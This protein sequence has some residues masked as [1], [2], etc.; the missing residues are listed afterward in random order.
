MDK[1]VDSLT[2]YYKIKG[3]VPLD[4]VE[5][6]RYGFKLI[7]SDIFNFFL[8]ISIGFILGETLSGIVFLITLCSI[9]QYSGGFHAKTFWLCRVSLLITFLCVIYITH[10]I[11]SMPFIIIIV[12]LLNMLSITLISILAPVK[13]PN[14]RLTHKQ[15]LRNKK[16]AVISSILFSVISIVL[17]LF[18][19]VEGVTVATTLLSVVILM[20]IGISILKGANYN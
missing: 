14:K 3:Y 7:L 18:N 4:K 2:N 16:N 5:I 9:R 19:I 12:S 15:R 8:V 17:T 6:Y 1:I 10:F 11:I 13:H 20:I